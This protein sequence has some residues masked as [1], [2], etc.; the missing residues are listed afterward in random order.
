MPRRL[1]SLFIHAYQAYIFNKVLSFRLKA[2]LPLKKAFEGD[3][4][5]LVD[6]EGF[7]TQQS[8]KVSLSNVHEANDLIE[9]GR[10]VLAINIIGFKTRLTAGLQGEIESRVLEEEGLTPKSFILASMPE[11]GSPGAIRPALFKPEKFKVTEISR[12]EHNLDRL[13]LT[14]SFTLKRG[15]YAT[16]GLREFMKP[17]NIIEAGF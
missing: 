1:L 14:L 13:K 8:I 2:G 6:D 10:A 12:D 15:F 17:Q 16:I 5:S 3:F 9:R 7:S 11:L 4:I